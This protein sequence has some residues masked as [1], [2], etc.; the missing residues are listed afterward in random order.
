[1]K[2]RPA[3]QDDIPN[4]SRTGAPFFGNASVD[5]L[6]RH[7]LRYGFWLGKV[8]FGRKTMTGI[9]FLFFGI[10]ILSTSLMRFVNDYYCLPTSKAELN[11]QRGILVEVQRSFRL[12][13][14]FVVK[15]TNDIDIHH[16]AFAAELARFIGDEIVIGTVKGPFYCDGYVM[17]IER[18]GTIIQD[19]KI[20]ID[21][22]KKGR[23]VDFLLLI[24][25]GLPAS[26][27][28]FGGYHLMRM[29]SSQLRSNLEKELND[30]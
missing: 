2:I 25:V 21:N 20:S 15:T 28:L 12:G 8:W 24:F 27:A 17:H 7:G 19:G 23:W 9:G 11:F 14:T 13:D 5:V 10:F 29:K 16:T 22:M 6:E 18:A 30:E 3:T 26:L 1:M 4:T